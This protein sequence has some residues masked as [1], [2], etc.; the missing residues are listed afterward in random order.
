MVKQP[1]QNKGL[2]LEELLRAYF[3]RS[4]YFVIRGVPLIMNNETLTD[5]DL[6][7]YGRSTGGAR[8][9]RICDIKYKLKPK[10][11]ERLFWTKGLATSL[12]IDAPILATTDKRPIL[13]SLSSDLKVE[14]IDGNIINRIQGSLDIPYKDRINDELVLSELQDIESTNQDIIQDRKILLSAVLKNLGKS[15]AVNALL[16]FSKFA[17]NTISSFPDSK[18]ALIFGRLAYLSAAITC[19][20]LDY[21]CAT[22]IYLSSSEK[23]R[24]LTKAIRFG[25]LDNGDSDNILGNTILLIEK[26]LPS[27]PTGEI[28]SSLMDSFNQIPA[29][30]IAEQVIRSFSNGTL[31]RSSRELEMASY[32]SILPSFDF[33]SRPTKSIVGALLDYSSINREKF[34]N[35]WN[36][37]ATNGIANELVDETENG[38]ILQ[39]ELQEK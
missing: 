21:Y 4:G 8:I 11:I 27:I 25:N 19:I 28:K 29:E 7:L 2:S 13:Q 22:K 32:L 37:I 34:A 31:Y 15:S 26:Q 39:R 16:L 35:A 24:V 6:W 36:N 38:L 12:E 1:K 10:A 5:I 20:S 17:Q 14:L 33:L 23:T 9:V 18:K 30:I 3:I